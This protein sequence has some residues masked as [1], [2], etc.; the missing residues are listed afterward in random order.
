MG[1]AKGER[2]NVVFAGRGEAVGRFWD[3]ESGLAIAP[4]P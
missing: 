3:S 4:C 2:G 1:G